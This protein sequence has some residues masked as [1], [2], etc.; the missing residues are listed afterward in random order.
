[1]QSAINGASA[2]SS[3]GI[4]VSVTIDADGKMNITS[5]KYGS[6]S[7]VSVTGT[8]ATALLG[9]PV[10]TD[11]LDVEGTIGGVK[12]GGSGQFLTGAPGSP[13]AGLKLEVKGGAENAARGSIN[14]SQGY[15][16]H[17]NNLVEGFLGSKGLLAGRT[18]GLKS[19]IKDIG[20]QN[21]RLQDRLAD[22]EK[23]YRAQFTALD[24]AISRMNS[25]SSFLTQQLAQ[26]GNLSQQ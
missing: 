7:K 17:L 8:A 10:V 19:G 21:E 4:A 1:V 11:G 16:F 24:V 18:D 12:A 14:F 26:L 13:A 20:K 25:T 2:L 23:R 15:A 5:N 6:T 3:A 9:T 22:I